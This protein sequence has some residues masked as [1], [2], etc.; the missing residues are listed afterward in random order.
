[1][2]KRGGFGAVSKSDAVTIFCWVCGGL[3][4]I[5]K[6]T[7]FAIPSAAKVRGVTGAD[8]AVKGCVGLASTVIR[9]SAL[10]AQCYNRVKDSLYALGP[11][12]AISL[13]APTELWV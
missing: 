13:T 5:A 12:L 3:S 1:M 2:L 6:L 4:T 9:A 8:V 11:F 7:V 10:I